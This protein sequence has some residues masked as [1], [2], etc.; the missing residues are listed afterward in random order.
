MRTSRSFRPSMPLPLEDRVVLSAIAGHAATNGPLSLPDVEAAL[1]Q[2]TVR[3]SAAEI[4]QS[5]ASDVPFGITTDGSIHTGMPVAENL[6]TTYVDGSTQTESLL[7]VPDTPNNTVTTY[8]TINLRNGGGTETVVD[9]ETFSGGTVPFSGTDNTHTLTTTLPDGAI[10]T[11]TESEVI[12]GHKTM[13]D[14]KI[15]EAG[16]GVETWT[17][18]NIRRGPKTTAEKTIVEPDGSKER[19][20]I[21]TTDHG[22][23][24]WTTRTTTTRPGEVV[25]SSSAT[26]VIRVQP[27]SS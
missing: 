13:I 7:K 9:T 1:R 26:N 3:L 22:N 10:Q 25:V 19:Q 4:A 2:R 12:V 23:L 8:K 17:S 24:D 11:E 14:A 27:P 5:N 18:V 16:G 6:A 20:R 15:H 21:I